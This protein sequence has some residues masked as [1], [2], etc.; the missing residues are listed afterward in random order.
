MSKEFKLPEEPSTPSLW[1]PVL[2]C[3]EA[4]SSR[5]VTLEDKLSRVDSMSFKA[6]EIQLEIDGLKEQAARPPAPQKKVVRMPI[7]PTV[8]DRRASV[9]ADAPPDAPRLDV[10]R[11]VRKGWV[12]DDFIAIKANHVIITPV[13]GRTTTAG[14]LHLPGMSTE[15]AGNNALAYRVEKISDLRAHPDP[16]IRALKVGDIVVIRSAMADFLIRDM[17][18]MT[19]DASHIYSVVWSA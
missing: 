10:E 17:S 4:I 3:W 11:I 12:V 16:M 7:V 9:A 18:W 1:N 14:G 5:V 6:V 8:I 19:V 15:A 2:Q 13:Q